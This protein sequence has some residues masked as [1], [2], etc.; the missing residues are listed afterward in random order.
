MSK[1]QVAV[2]VSESR[3]FFD[4]GSV[5]GKRIFCMV[6]SVSS[7]SERGIAPLKTPMS[8]G[9]FRRSSQGADQEVQPPDDFIFALY[10][11]FDLVR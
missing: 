10:L 4:L 6:S 3:S 8:V 7:A 9:Y 11:H 2:E 5:S 1:L